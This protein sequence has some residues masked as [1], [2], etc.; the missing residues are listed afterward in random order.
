[1][2]I[3]KIV[4]EK[5]R[6]ELIPETSFSEQSIKEVQDLQRILVE[7]PDVLEEGLFIIGA[8]FSEWQESRRRIDLLAL[9]QAGRLVVVEL[10]RGETG[11][12]S[13]LQAIRYAAMVAN[14]TFGKVVDTYKAYFEVTEEE[15]RSRIHKHLKIPEEEEAEIDTEKPRIILACEGFSKELTTSV[16]WLNDCELDIKCIR[17]KTYRI[18]EEILVETSQLIPLPEASKFRE[19]F[20]ERKREAREQR[21]GEVQHSSGKVQNTQG[22]DAFKESI[23]QASEKFQPG[24]KRL[25]DSAVDLE[26][27]KLVELSTYI[28]GREEYFRLN[29]LVPGKDQQLVS[30]NHHLRYKGVECGGEIT[31]WPGAE[32]FA[33]NSLPR[34]DELIGE[35]KSKSDLRHRRL[36]KAKTSADLNAILAVINYA[37]REANG[38][39]TDAAITREDENTGIPA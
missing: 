10:K 1:M 27:N 8:E 15:A 11:D 21:S 31:F 26:R 39:E 4:G 6:L 9:D 12:H 25:Y 7:Q 22:A 37:Y 2:A 19:Q 5:E 30:F 3:Y 35:A 38:I 33:P 23:G 16:L 34:I 17:F 32:N 14:L 13:E 28:N 29:L 24:L 36:S 20:L 18:G